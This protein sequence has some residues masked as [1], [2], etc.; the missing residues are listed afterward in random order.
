MPSMKGIK[1]YMRRSLGNKI[2]VCLALMFPS[3]CSDLYGQRDTVYF[4]KISE[5]IYSDENYLIINGIGEYHLFGMNIEIGLDEVSEKAFLR[6]MKNDSVLLDVND[7]TALSDFNY[8]DKNHSQFI[9]FSVYNE[10]LDQRKNG[11]VFSIINTENNVTVNELKINETSAPAVTFDEGI[12]LT[13]SLNLIKFDI[14]LKEELEKYEIIFSDLLK[15]D[16]EYLD[17]YSIDRVVIHDRLL[18]IWFSPN[19]FRSEY[20]CY[21]GIIDDLKKTKVVL[22]NNLN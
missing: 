10:I 21:C 14:G 4:D 16:F 13:K 17:T 15:G 20:V 2:T 22:L 8:F 6:V 9:V 5:N 7:I 19:A 1:E 12:Y 3:L 11:F 18:C